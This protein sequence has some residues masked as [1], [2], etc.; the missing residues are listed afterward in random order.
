MKASAFGNSKFLKKEDFPTPQVLTIKSATVEEVA[1]G[2]AKLC[3]WFNEA[4]KPLTLNNT[5]RNL[6]I[7]TYGDDTDQWIGRKVRLS[8]DPTVMYGGQPVGGIKLECSKSAA[9]VPAPKPAA[10]PSAA[11]ADDSDIPF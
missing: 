6:L 4:V 2:D 3:I 9:A 5:K 8:N 1:K 10:P 11:F 7:A